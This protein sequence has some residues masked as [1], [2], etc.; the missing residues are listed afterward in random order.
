M[1]DV[2]ALPPR[3]VSKT[4]RRLLGSRTF[5]IGAVLTGLM[6]LIAVLAPL[7]A[8]HDPL[9]TNV[10]QR[11]QPPSSEHWMGTDSNGRDLY[12]RVVYGARVSL[13]VGLGVVVF[14]T[15]VGSILGLAAGYVRP[16]D[17][18]IMR[19]MD[20]WMAFPGIMLALAIIAALGASPA[21]VVIALTITYTP[22]T[23][24]VVRG[25]VLTLRE[26]TYVEAA[27]GLGAGRLRIMFRHILP[28]ATSP[29][30]V[31]GT[32]ILALAVLAEAALSYIGAGIAPPRPSWGNILADGQNYLHTA[33]WIT[34]FP[35]VFIM[36]SVLGLN[37]LGD[38]LRDALDPRTTD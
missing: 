15:T 36:L 1:S 10:R 20:G 32:F 33:P 14:T 25:V 29:I 7:L 17:G 23:A 31:Q 26:L 30:I 5:M 16:L 13:I 4:R 2:A 11:L 8:T 22:R 18:P 34:I 38:G 27:Q 21:N 12:S 3:M 24:R 35:G 28:N 37:L 19:L 9:R 6:V